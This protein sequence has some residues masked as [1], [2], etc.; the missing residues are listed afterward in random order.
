MEVS[1]GFKNER[2]VPTITLSS[3]SITVQSNMTE[4]NFKVGKLVLRG[5]L[6][7]TNISPSSVDDFP[8]FGWDM[9]LFPRRLPHFEQNH[10]RETVGRPMEPGALIIES[11]RIMARCLNT[12]PDE[13][14]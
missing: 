6:L 5:T 13:W 1:P 8:P 7:V 9:D 2:N 4:I 11:N 10:F 14:R 3:L 12:S